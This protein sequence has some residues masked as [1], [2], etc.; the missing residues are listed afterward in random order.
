MNMLTVLVFLTI[1]YQH[2]FQNFFLSHFLH[3]MNSM[4]NAFYAI[5]IQCKKCLQM[6][7][8]N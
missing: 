1:A 6:N 5:F 2:F 7:K 3:I 8:G 4:I